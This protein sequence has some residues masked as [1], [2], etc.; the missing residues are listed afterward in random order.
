MK[1]PY[2]SGEVETYRLII[3]SGKEVATQRCSLCG[4]VPDKKR[5]FLPKKEIKDFDKLPLFDDFSADAPACGYMGCQNK[6][7]EYHHYAPRHLFDDA[8]FWETGFLCLYHHNLWHE[9]TRTGSYY[10]QPA[11][12]ESGEN[13]NKN[14]SKVIRDWTNETLVVDFVNAI[15]ETYHYEVP[16]NAV[17][18]LPTRPSDSPVS[19]HAKV[20]VW[21]HFP[22]ARQLDMFAES[23]TK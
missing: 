21:M 14:D 23:E 16:P 8:D 9:R 12:A 7:T 20:M 19:R 17:D 4:R 22:V 11:R 18:K 15:G 13:M 10:P 2:C 1:C 5:P 3:S 6:G